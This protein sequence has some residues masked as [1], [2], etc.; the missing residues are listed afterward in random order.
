MLGMLPVNQLQVQAA[1]SN[2]IERTIVAG[3]NLEITADELGVEVSPLDTVIYK[4]KIM[5]DGTDYTGKYIGENLLTKSVQDRFIIFAVDGNCILD[6]ATVSLT[7]VSQMMG[8]IECETNILIKATHTVGDWIVDKEAT[9]EEPGSRYKECSVCKYKMV[10][11]SIL[12]ENSVIKAIEVSGVELPKLG[13]K[14]GESSIA[15]E[16]LI[17]SGEY[18]VKGAKFLVYDEDEET[19]TE[20]SEDTAFEINVKYCLSL[21]LE[22][23][24]GYVFDTEMESIKING[25]ATEIYEI[26][27]NEV[28][29]KKD[30]ANIVMEFQIDCIHSFTEKIK[31]SKH[32]VSGS[33]SDCSENYYY[34]FDC[35]YC[36]V[37]S[38]EDTWES[39]KHGSHNLDDDSYCDVCEATIYNLWVGSTEINSENADDVF[40]D[41]TVSYNPD[42][43]ILKLNGYVND[44]ESYEYEEDYRAGIFSEKDLNLEIIGVNSIK[45]T[46][47]TGDYYPSGIMCFEGNITISG[48]GKLEV[49]SS[50]LICAGDGDVIIYG[51]K[52]VMSGQAGIFGNEIQIKG[53]DVSIVADEVC[54]FVYGEGNTL[55][56]TDGDL[57]M[58]SGGFG[59][60]IYNPTVEEDFKS[61]PPNLSGYKGYIASAAVP[62]PRGGVYWEEYN[63]ESFDY[64]KYIILKLNKIPEDEAINSVE[65]DNFRFPMVGETLNDIENTPYTLTYKGKYVMYELD[66]FKIVEDEQE[67]V[68][69]NEVFKEGQKYTFRL[70]IY[71][72]CEWGFPSDLTEEDI[73]INGKKGIY[74]AFS[75]RYLPGMGYE[76][77]S[78]IMYGEFYPEKP[79]THSYENFWYKDATKH[80]KLCGCGEKDYLADHIYDVGVITKAPTEKVTGI[81]TYTCTVCKATKTEVVP[82]KEPV[83]TPV[84]NG[85]VLKD[86][87]GNSYKVTKTGKANGTVSYVKPKSKKATNIKIPDTVKINGIVY[88]ITSI[89]KNAFKNNKKITSVTIGKNIKTIGANAFSGCSKLKTV[90]MGASVTTIGDKAFYKCTS[91]TKI[92]IPAKVKKIGK[93]AFYGCKKLKNIT[94]KT[95]LLNKKKVG[96]NA[97]KGINA[98][99]NINV[100]K[101]K[102]KIYK[103]MLKSRGVGKRVKFKKK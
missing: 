44:G 41:G 23:I 34:Y 102:F 85:T 43:N 6:G 84:K 64:E 75:N 66:W 12:Y 57:Y 17:C 91:L 18:L 39:D 94:I 77:D 100:P 40:G 27:E 54:T 52:L 99:A 92:T 25:E 55:E 4:W 61:I 72:D 26:Y 16:D 36:D 9:E 93:S 101:A 65:I 32:I 96:K 90:K 97:F 60:L 80:W 13:D 71:T 10:T 82:V 69:E 67:D 30:N 24:A 74:T 19:W 70:V 88:K 20:L 33:G 78:L 86:K 53:G 3:E 87:N 98:K 50:Q 49:Y 14:C 37:I 38:T 51:G 95:K 29:G 73:T 5:K 22:T 1:A 47:E 7:V 8:T 62:N 21:D 31:D 89:E 58:M 68:D 103:P 81:K 15:V 28:S 48:T 46:T 35:A 76:K 56:M 11:E 59:G 83:K 63:P 2:V 42:T 45:N 79:H